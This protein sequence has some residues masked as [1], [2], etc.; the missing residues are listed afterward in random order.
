M[1]ELV[2]Y[3]NRLT[4]ILYVA[5]AFCLLL[6]AFAGYLYSEKA[7]PTEIVQ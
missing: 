1:K 4:K 2:A 5:A 3:S 7:T 6:G